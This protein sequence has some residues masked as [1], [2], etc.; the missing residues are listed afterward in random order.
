MLFEVQRNTSLRVTPRS[1]A[2]VCLMADYLGVPWGGERGCELLWVGD[3]ALCCELPLGWEVYT[4]DESAT[5]YYHNTVTGITC[6]E[7]PQISFLRGVAEA[8]RRFAD[9][10]G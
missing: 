3:A 9:A 5:S 2:D 10:G 4:H 8:A 7:H 1:L 6:W